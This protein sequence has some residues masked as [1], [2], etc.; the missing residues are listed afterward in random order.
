V[1]LLRQLAGE[2]VHL[3]GG[4]PYVRLLLDHAT[5]APGVPGPRRPRSP[6]P[7]SESPAPGRGR[8]RR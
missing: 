8:Q 2:G 1:L 6:R 7:P 5:A 3:L 4:S